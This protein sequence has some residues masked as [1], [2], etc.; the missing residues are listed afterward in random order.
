MFDDVSHTHKQYR[1][2]AFY[3]FN[4]TRL[5]GDHARL[6]CVPTVVRLFCSG[7]W[8]IMCTLK[9]ADLFLCPTR[10]KQQAAQSTTQSKVVWEFD[11]L[12]V[13]FT[14]MQFFPFL[15]DRVMACV[16]VTQIPSQP[17]VWR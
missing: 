1:A 13:F 2:Y 16:S 15:E 17:L 6:L 8:F 14:F 3:R 4:L 10:Q 5:E 12:M 7:R 9:Q 11:C